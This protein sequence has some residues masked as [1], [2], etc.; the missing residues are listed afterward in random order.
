LL[1]FAPKIGAGHPRSIAST[2]GRIPLAAATARTIALMA[3][4]T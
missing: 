4:S 1:A 2:H 3:A